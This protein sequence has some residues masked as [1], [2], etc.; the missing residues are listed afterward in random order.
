MWNIS[1]KFLRH[2]FSRSIQ[3]S[4]LKEYLFKNSSI[5]IFRENLFKNYYL[6]FFETFF[7]EI[8]FKEK[9]NT[10]IF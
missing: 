5:W 3:V 6:I 9:F 1:K 2:I 8:I 4:I 7:K 10:Y